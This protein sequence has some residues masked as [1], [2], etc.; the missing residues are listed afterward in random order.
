MLI[1][2]EL[3]W[4]NRNCLIDEAA[5]CLKRTMRAGRVQEIFEHR[6]WSRESAGRR[7]SPYLADDSLVPDDRRGGVN[8]GRARKPHLRTLKGVGERDLRNKQPLLC[9]TPLPCPSKT[10]S[11]FSVVK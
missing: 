11:V 9:Q 7:A 8:H 4:I 2:E 3:N 10:A 1:V 6:D 5:G